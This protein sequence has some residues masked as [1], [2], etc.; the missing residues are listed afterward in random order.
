MKKNALIILFL[1]LFIVSSCD[2]GD[3]ITGEEI[4]PDLPDYVEVDLQGNGCSGDNLCAHVGD[5]YYD[6]SS[7]DS[8][9]QEFYKFNA[10]HLAGGAHN[11]E[12]DLL[13]LNSYNSVYY[14][15]S[16]SIF[17]GDSAYYELGEEGDYQSAF[18]ASIIALSEDTTISSTLNGELLLT[19]TNFSILDSII[20]NESSNRYNFRTV[21]AQKDTTIF[22]YQHPFDS[23]FYETIVDVELNP[24]YGDYV[25][26]DYEEDVFRN[27]SSYDTLVAN[28]ISSP[29]KIKRNKSFYIKDYYV[30]NNS[31]MFRESTD[32]NDNYR[33]DGPEYSKLDIESMCVDSG[34]TW[35]NNDTDEC[36]SY[37]DDGDGILQEG[38]ATFDDMCWD[39]YTSDDRLTGRCYDDDSIEAFCDTG[40]NLW[41]G[42]EYYYDV[43]GNGSFNLIGQD[44]EPWEDRNC[45]G[46]YDSSNEE[47]LNEILDQSAC[48]EANY[49]SWDITN[50][51]CFYDSGNQ[52]KDI[53]EA[54]YTGGSTGCDYTNLY[55]R[56]DSPSMF[57]VDYL[58]SESPAP[59]L[60]A[61]PS[62][63]FEDCG[64]DGLCNEHEPGYNPGTC[65]DGYSGSEQDCCKYNFCWDYNLGTC[66]YSLDS[67][68][69]EGGEQWTELLDPN[70]DDWAD[71]GDGVW[72]EG[73]GTEHNLL[74]DSGELIIKDYNNNDLWDY[75][76]SVTNK[77]LPYSLCND[78]CGNLQTY[79]IEDSLR[80][81]PSSVSVD[82]I[83]SEIS[84]KSYN[85][86]DQI[87]VDGADD[88]IID[89]LGSYNIVKTDFINTSGS[90]DYDY[91][92]FLES[93]D[94][95]ANGMHYVIKLIHPYYYFAP[96]F[97]VPLDVYEFSNDDFWQTLDLEADTLIYSL[98]GQVIEGQSYYSTKFIESDTANYNVHK[99]Y[100]VERATAFREY[101]SAVPDC[102]KVERV[103]T[104]TMVGSGVSFKIKSE[105]Y[106]KPDA[107]YPLVKEDIYVFWT[108]APWEGDTWYPISSIEFKDEALSRM[109]SRGF[110]E[111]R[112][113]LDL[114]TMANKSDF[115]FSPFRFTNTIGLQR[116]E[117]PNE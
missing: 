2:D 36:A 82:K 12:V 100:T 79:I 11:P 99:E 75:A 78:D 68:L 103:V 13:N 80:Q 86:I 25:L 9:S 106:L 1:S 23:V 33:Q 92:L 88:D 60:T 77:Q 8:Y 89:L 93:D 72:Q 43:D 24:I 18:D 41:D 73:E 22:T 50:N 84:V 114:N 91:M 74:Y 98:D 40:N 111:S 6:F 26:V 90:A 64:E 83:D 14:I 47:I 116:I 57:L 67:C 61:Y 3:Q 85:V 51:L 97:Y 115:D 52:M 107:G 113:P 110:L 81:I 87:E 44:Y 34:G 19:S 70:Q 109:P 46:S 48:N 65:P 62:D 117:Y 45:N 4:S 54:C 95:D 58:D 55:K 94:Q 20:W 39:L 28:N 66:D 7:D 32:C 30:K 10:Y 15:P 69:F 29:V 108:S 16:S 63:D 21:S 27:Y 56:A 101:D 49:A 5:L 59:I 42:Q 102:F 104:T 105:T 17:D 38:E 35:V 76:T 37:C 53:Q 31:L 96:G 71:N 112:K